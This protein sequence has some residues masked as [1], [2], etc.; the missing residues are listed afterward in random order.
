MCSLDMMTHKT[1]PCESYITLMAQKMFESSEHDDDKISSLKYLLQRGHEK[2]MN[3]IYMTTHKSFL[4]KDFT[5]L[6]RTHARNPFVQ[7]KL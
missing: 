1:F 2:L 7:K 3:L 6:V 4:V 5:Q